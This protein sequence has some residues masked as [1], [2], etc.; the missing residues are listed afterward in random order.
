M[1]NHSQTQS[2]V[3]QPDQG[4]SFWQPVPANG[5]IELK[6]SNRNGLTHQ[7]F[8]CGVQSVAPGGFVR[9]HAHNANEE[10]IFVYQGEGKAIVDDEEHPMQ[11]GTTF[12]LDPLRTHQ[13]INS[14][15]SEL[16]FF[17]VL[18]PG[19]LSRFFEAI[20]RQRLPGETAPEPFP[21]PDNIAEI[22]ANTVFAK[23]TD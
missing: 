16:R 8:D 21:R 19:G 15:D 4:E 2:I 3:V 23:L 9:K 1:Q 10:L 14:G 7:N 13:F 17:W 11:P 12:Y 6:I 5:F 20:G 18:L 22:E